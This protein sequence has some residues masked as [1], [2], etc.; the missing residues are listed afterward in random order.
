MKILEIAF[1][2]L[3]HIF[4]SVF[5]LVMMF[6]APLLIAGLIYFAFSGL[7][8]GSGNA[9]IPVIKVQ[10][11]NLDQ[12]GASA[13]LAAG[14]M[15]VNFLQDESL[16]SVISI[17]LAE[18]EA[19]ARAAVDTQKAGVA[20]I[21]PPDFS[22]AVTQ[23][24]RSAAVTLYHDPTLTFAPGLV[25]DLV[26]HF[27]D[28]FSGAKITSQVTMAQ[29]AS[30]GSQPDPSAGAQAVQKYTA[31][32]QANGHESENS[33][34]TE[35]AITSPSKQEQPK[36]VGAALIGPIM[37][38]MMIFFVFFMG[39]N[40]A[41]SIIREDE[42]GTLARLFT[43]PTKLAAILGGKFLG[44]VVSLCIQVALL[45]LASSLLFGISWGKAG[46]VL[47]VSAGL[48]V[49]SAGFGIMLMSFIK[50]SRQTG[51]VLGG[52][53][54]LTGMLG[55]LMTTAIP[56]LPAGFETVTLFTPQGW[57]MQ[58]WKLALSG[59][60]PGGVL[61]PVLVMLASG[62]AFLAIGVVLFRKRFA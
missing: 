43:T 59:M 18:S 61:L 9:S 13:E 10:V 4:K 52:V 27:M 7:A 6:A 41:E 57:A 28:S 14:K 2:D 34:N 15:L 8:S 48:I 45:M 36:S 19:A 30:T 60:G 1:K 12:P 46:S 38:G 55:G 44:V 29:L 16:A 20:I 21:I 23:P 51:P 47:L 49:A 53:M 31:W 58:G 25:K 54:T 17:S 42:Q 32:L 62:L 39:A 50:N 37:A 33:A 56:N 24:E 5:S 40:G 22:A 26:A 11:A 35:L 3:K